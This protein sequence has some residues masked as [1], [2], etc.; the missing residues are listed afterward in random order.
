MEATGIKSG[1][2]YPS[3]RELRKTKWI[4]SDWQHSD[5]SGPDVPPII[6]YRLTPDGVAF[7]SELDKGKIQG[8]MWR[9]YLP[10]EIMWA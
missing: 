1:S 5:Q 9:R 3:M 8:T 4:E 2:F 10:D 6:H 7:A